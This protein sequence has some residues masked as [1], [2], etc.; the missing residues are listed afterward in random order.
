M[1]YWSSKNHKEIKSDSSSNYLMA[2]DVDGYI[3]IFD[4]GNPGKE[5]VSKR[6]GNAYGN[7]KMRVILWKDKGREIISGDEE[8]YVTFW[9]SK[10]GQPLYVMKAHQ[11]PITQMRWNEDEQ[12]L[13]TGSKDKTIKLWQIPNEWVSEIERKGGS[14]RQ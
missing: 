13:I 11:G 8:G 10:D 1:E 3:T 6:I 7:K 14:T 2:S 5:K 9:N 12:Q 4:I